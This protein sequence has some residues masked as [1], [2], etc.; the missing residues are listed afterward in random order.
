MGLALLLFTITGFWL[1]Y[2]P[3]RMKQV[4]EIIQ[5]NNT[6]LFFFNIAPIIILTLSSAKKTKIKVNT[7]ISFRPDQKKPV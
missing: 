5:I 4:K 6:S 2:G 1:W 3:K 7:L